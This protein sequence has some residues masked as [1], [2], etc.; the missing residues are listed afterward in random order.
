MKGPVMLIAHSFKRVRMLVLGIALLLGAF[1]LLLILVAGAFQQSN[2]LEGMT[3]LLP[4]FVR[5]FLGSSVT[6]FLSFNGLI[7]EGYFHPVVLASLIGLTIAIST[8]PTSE[9]ESGFMDLILSRPIARHWV[10][11]R[12]IIVMVSCTM[13]VLGVMLAGTWLGLSAFAP[14]NIAL[15]GPGP[16]VSL[17]VNLGVL[18]MCWSGVAMAIGSASRR[19]SI[20]GTVTAL[21][22]LATFLI[23]LLGHAWRPLEAIA[24]LSPFRY[25]NA[26]ELIRGVPLE[27]TDL[28]V[29]ASIS[30]GG[31]ITAFVIFGIRDLSP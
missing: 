14:K 30:I 12:S 20:A 21:L 23:D 3:D 1:Q 16:I 22:A 9:I 10:I 7:C 15:P 25:Y 11:T 19:R 4:P 24:W 29:L 5:E 18:M 27:L 8:M 28:L 31:F 17:A 2:A 26:L 6:A 13:A